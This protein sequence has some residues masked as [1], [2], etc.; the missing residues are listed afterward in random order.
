MS[1]PMNRLSQFRSYSYYHVLAMCD[2]SATADAL[3]QSQELGIWEHATEATA[4]GDDRAQSKNLGRYAPKRLEES[5]KY[6]IL[7]NGSSDAAYVITDAKWS[8]ATAS[9]A[10]PGDR[11]T[12]IAVEGTLRVSEPKGIAFLDQV[13]QCSVALGV[14]AAQVVFVLKT[15]FV[16]H[17]FDHEQGEYVDHIT[18]I[19][20]IN[21]IAYD[22]QGTFT[23]SGG[24]YVIEFVA[25]AHGASRLPQYGKSVNAMNITAGDSLESTFRRLQD[26]IN[27]NYDQYF[28]CVYNQ[29]AAADG[30]PEKEALLKSLRRVNYVIEVGPDYSDSNGHVKYT[31]TNQPQQFKNTAGC[32][33]N[34]QISFPSSSSIEGA[35]NSIMLMSPQV[36]LDMSQGDTST[37]VKY[38]Y[39]VHSA[40]ESK[41]VDG[42]AADTLEYTVYYR[43]ERFMTPKSLTFDADFQV[44]S[45]D[46]EKLKDNPHYDMLKRNI[47][48][49]DYM[50]TGKNI[51]IL[52]F[53][54]KINMGMAYLQTATLANTFKSQL[55]RSSNRQMQASS[56]DINNQAV[57]FGGALVQ[58]PVFFGSQIKAPTLTNQQ[59]A[60]TAIQSAY[61]LS[62]HASLEVAEASMVIIG[63]DQLLGTTNRITSPEHVMKTVD[64]QESSNT[65]DAADFKDW[66]LIPAY[67]KINIKMPRDNDDF[68]LYTGQSSSGD[69]NAVGATDYARDF[70]FDG[71][72][73]V[74]GIEHIFEGGEFKQNLQ[75]VGIPQ[76]SAFDSAQG[77]N[78]RDV[79]ATQTVG[80]CFDNQIGAGSSIP[81]PNGGT[82]AN[83][84]VPEVP[85]S[86]TTV[87]TNI[88][89]SKTV[90]ASAGGP[91]NVRGW[92]KAS[93]AV[94][95]AIRD[96]AA[97]Y[98]VDLTTM[99]QFAAKESS[100]NPTAHPK[101][102]V[103][104][105]AGL[106]QFLKGT[107]NG[108]VKA[109]S[110]IG[111]TTAN[112]LV[113]TAGKTPAANDPRYN[114]QL[115]AY[116]GAAFLRDNARSIGSNDAGDLYLAHFLGP[117]TAKKVIA[118][119]RTTGGG[120]LL[121]TVLGAD[122]AGD[123]ARANPSI[124]RSTTTCLELRNWAAN[125]MAKL[126]TNQPPTATQQTTAANPQAPV[127]PRT[128]DQPIAAIQNVA[129]QSEK[130]NT[131]NCGPTAQTVEETQTKPT[132]S[133]IDSTNT[134]TPAGTATA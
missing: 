53:D 76:K 29:I 108:L 98:N 58:T 120:T 117:N 35:I 119:C 68:S 122:T 52:E 85:P 87:P 118:N 60:S 132:T 41:P 80:S 97:R 42:A 13:V 21:F 32:G 81:A 75:M 11:G 25:A 5:G 86:G 30:G 18:D 51:D 126:L 105:A 89:D 2:C 59:N 121:S 17:A 124:V 3:A 45:Q 46:K 36:Q 110:V 134:A 20:P 127:V 55:E 133:T 39:K 74:Y 123:I 37:G 100:F 54:M 6:I 130:N 72:Y 40:L 38:E 88:A 56:Q 26:N 67:A 4:A 115:N 27:Q 96:A 113:T 50:Y 47:I 79:N 57:R 77:D 93:P 131:V 69:P 84:A 44:L 90:T 92:S 48:E 112:G 15:F 125:S 49:F 33:D 71:Y 102:S 114:P 73:Y 24:S 91:E 128:A 43:V 116:A 99:A 34:A 31:V 12:S 7:I 62:K 101:G 64:R 23:E 66:S 82:A 106:Y 8:S 63:N 1:S 28:Q 10:V 94:Q 9:S 22:V 16:G 70:W 109:G 19:P 95:A 103:S 111:V 14:D 78:P 83:T 104:S 65:P 107:W 129:V 61:T